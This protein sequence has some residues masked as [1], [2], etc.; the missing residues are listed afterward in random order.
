MAQA[1]T[2]TVLH[3]FDGRRGEYPV[4]GLAADPV[5]GYLYGTA[6]QGGRYGAGVLF[7]LSQAG[8]QILHDFSGG[9]DGAHPLGS[10]LLDG[11]GH[12]YGTTYDGGTPGGGTLFRMDATGRYVQLAAL[13]GSAQGSEIL[14]GLTLGGDGQL[15]GA[16]SMGGSQGLGTLLRIDPLTGSIVVIHDFDGTDGAWPESTPVWSGG[17]IVGTTWG[18]SVYA[19]E[20]DGS[21]FQVVDYQDTDNSFLYAAPTPDASGAWWGAMMANGGDVGDLWRIGADG[22]FSLP[23]H[24]DDADRHDGANPA[25]TLLIGADG[26]LYGTTRRGGGACSCGTVFRFDPASGT[27]ETLH[28]FDDADGREPW[29]GLVA[30][31][32][33]NFYGVAEYG[34]KHGLG[35]IYRITP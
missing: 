13:D 26:M 31:G 34:G 27:L 18:G 15:Y 24:F 1:A 7:R 32:Q 35:V 6:T 28:Q 12:L 20:S 25:G 30:D 23:Y 21:D 17:E 14:A 11:S 5:G 4:G 19:L 9:S 2:F 29:A 33:G 22:S 10:V 3:N 8:Y 16:A